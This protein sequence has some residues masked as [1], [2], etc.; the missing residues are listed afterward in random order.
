MV[1]VYRG[2][3]VLSLFL[4]VDCIL[5]WWVNF[6]TRPTSFVTAPV[7]TGDQILITYALVGAAVIVILATIFYKVKPVPAN[8]RR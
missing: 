5:I 6:G 2:Y 3:I 7:S 1:H 8:L 4:V